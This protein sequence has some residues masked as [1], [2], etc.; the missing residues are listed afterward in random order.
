MRRMYTESSLLELF[1]SLVDQTAETKMQEEAGLSHELQDT[2]VSNSLP[3]YPHLRRVPQPP[4]T[5]PPTKN[6]V[7]ECKYPDQAI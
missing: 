3:L 6:Q 5:M 4:K 1:V 7:S 2:P